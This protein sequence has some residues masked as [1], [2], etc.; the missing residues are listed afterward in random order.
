MERALVKN[1]DNSIFIHKTRYAMFRDKVDEKFIEKNRLDNANNLTTHE[2]FSA[3]ETDK[4]L[5]DLSNI[6]S[7]NIDVATVNYFK[8]KYKAIKIFNKAFNMMGN[9]VTNATGKNKLSF[10]LPNKKLK[11][12]KYKA[13]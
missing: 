11:K 9:V 4:L 3:K 12:V 10:S 2:I 5:S 1:S 8:K 13:D 6:I 7:A